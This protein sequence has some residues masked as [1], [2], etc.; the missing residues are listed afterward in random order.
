MRTAPV[1]LVGALVAGGALLA[2]NGPFDREPP[3]PQ[4]DIKTAAYELTGDTFSI[5][6]SGPVRFALVTGTA[7]RIQVTSRRSWAGP[8]E[9]SQSWD[10]GA[11]EI[12]YSCDEGCRADYTITVP[13]GTRVT[14]H[15]SATRPAA[16]PAG[17]TCD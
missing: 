4:S 9:H 7:G 5:S 3:V 6:A 12:G 15:G 10:D 17:I 14:F 11:L 16:C 13:A 8:L 1:L 2:A